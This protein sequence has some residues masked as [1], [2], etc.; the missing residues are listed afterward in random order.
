[1]ASY[2]GL[3]R[4]APP[5]RLKMY[6]K[7]RYIPAPND[8]DWTSE[9]RGT[10]FVRSIEALLND[11]PDRQQDTVKAELDH[12]HTIADANGLT[13]AERVCAGHGIDLEG[14]EGIQARHISPQDHRPR[15][16][17]HVTLAVF[18]RKRMGRFP[19]GSERQAVDAGR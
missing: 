5:A 3:L 15:F 17:G 4:K 19:I 18:R 2:S 12:L 6:L 9:G 1:M 13:A 16:C 11:L 8:F 7:A 10:A 14:L